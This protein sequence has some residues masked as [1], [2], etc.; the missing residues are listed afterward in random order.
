MLTRLVGAGRLAGSLY[1][2]IDRII[3]KLAPLTAGTGVPLFGAGAAMRP[4][5]GS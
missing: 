2:E 1:E 3:L 5:T 4:G